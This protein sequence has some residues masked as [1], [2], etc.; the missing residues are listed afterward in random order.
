MPICGDPWVD[1]ISHNMAQ[2]S[3][4]FVE[5]ISDMKLQTNHPLLEHLERIYDETRNCRLKDPSFDH[6]ESEMKIACDYFK[7]NRFQASLLATM[8]AKGHNG[9]SVSF[10]KLVRHFDCGPL[11]LLRNQKEIDDLVSRNYLQH[12][13][14]SKNFHGERRDSLYQLNERLINAVLKEAPFPELERDCFK[15]VIDALAEI[16]DLDKDH[17]VN[18]LDLMLS[19]EEVFTSNLHFPLLK[20]ID[21]FR[22]RM[23]DL[24][25]LINVLWS[26]IAG[27]PVPNLQRLV[28]CI[29][30]DSSENIKYRRKLLSGQNRLV[31]LKLIEVSESGFFDDVEVKLTSKGIRML[32]EHEIKIYGAAAKRDNVILCDELC[33][34]PLFFEDET[35]RQLSLLRDALV[36]EKMTSIRR[37]LKDRGLSEG[38]AT[39]FYGAPGTGKTEMAKQIARETGRDVMTVEISKTK[40]MWFGES[41]KIIKKVF[42]EYASFNE[43]C[44]RIPILLFN[45]ADAVFSKRTSVTDSNVV[46]TENAIQNIILE[47]LE[48]FKGILIATTNLQDNLDAAFE[49]RFLFKVQFRKPDIINRARIWESKLKSLTHEDARNLASQYDFSGGEIDNIVRKWEIHSLINGEADVFSTIERF[50]EEERLGEKTR[51]IGFGR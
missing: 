11:R 21:G 24:Y 47:E 49:R 4:S 2:G 13:K 41:E 34:K 22:L 26:T 51:S 3:G 6:L 37:R 43:E 29:L 12:R 44:E 14:I 7:V 17:D 48:N 42:S 46:K 38:I 1:I 15:D 39:L 40:S 8:F 25:I 33:S 32:K 9:E 28:D 36:D 35:Q 27:D 45:E 16:V 23:D 50:C 5:K 20:T 31:Q 30:E 19:V 18:G 10:D